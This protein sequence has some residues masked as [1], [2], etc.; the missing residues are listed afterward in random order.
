[1]QN[2]LGLDA[3]PFRDGPAAKLMLL[4]L[5]AGGAVPPHPSDMVV[6]FVVLA[7][8]GTALDGA[9]RAEVSP[10]DT[11]RFQPGGLHGFQ[12]GEAGLEM[13]VVKHAS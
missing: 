1:M 2:P 8:A 7:G 5:P 11:V 12:A 3:R 6:D 13:L 9:E 10:G 4:R